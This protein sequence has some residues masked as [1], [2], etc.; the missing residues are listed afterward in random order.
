MRI[1]AVGDSDAGISAA[2]RIREGVERETTWP[3]QI[4]GTVPPGRGPQP[5][6]GGLRRR[7]FSFGSVFASSAAMMWYPGVF[8]WMLKVP[9]QK[10]V[11]VQTSPP[12][13]GS[14][15]TSGRLWPRTAERAGGLRHVDERRTDG[16]V[17]L[18]EAWVDVVLEGADRSGDER[19]VFAP[20]TVG[21][22]HSP[23][24]TSG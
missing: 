12:A 7:Y 22:T 8:M 24:S 10:Y 2:L 13:P 21:C 15:R 14:D 19:S 17:G 11:R 18:L 20:R 16:V 6:A 9:S 5:W 1:V 4:E 3:G 23:S